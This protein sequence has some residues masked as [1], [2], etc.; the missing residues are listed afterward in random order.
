M[1][2]LT[3]RWENL[4]LLNYIC[5]AALLE[6]LVP[7]G[8]DL[9]TW[10][11]HTLISLVGFLFSDTRLLGVPVPFH[12]TFEEINLRF[13]V[14]RAIPDHRAPSSSFVNSSPVELSQRSPR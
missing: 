5:P 11:G 12:R 7:A 4:I 9:D 8:T 10:E 13:Y 6:P 2:F 3:A 14:R 1:P